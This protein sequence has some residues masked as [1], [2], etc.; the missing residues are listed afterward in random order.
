MP[1]KILIAD[2]DPIIIDLLLHTLEAEGFEVLVAMDGERAL[3]QARSRQPDLV[4]LDVVMPCLQGLDV[5]RE[6][7]R[8]SDVPILMLTAHDE[9][10]DRI[11][12][13]DLGADDY[14]A[15]PFKSGELLARIRAN[16]RRA[17]LSAAPATMT[18][19]AHLG[20]VRIDRRRHAVSRGMT[21]VSLTQREYDLLLAL[22]DGR[23]AVMPRGQ[24]LAKVWGE[25][26][27]GDQRTLDV[28]IRWLR[29]KL[30]EKP[31]QPKLLLTVRNVGYRLVSAEELLDAHPSV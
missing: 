10:N 30:E 12:G 18:D 8:E 4:L 28:H 31:A 6:I 1:P 24:L 9:E 27:I 2:D 22:L 19:I 7:R 29:E 15:K 17:R 23:G 13:L 16:L 21:A 25:G 3:Q 5:C 20:N 14:I 11:L 26:W